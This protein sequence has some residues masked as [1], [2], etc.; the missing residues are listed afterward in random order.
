MPDPAQVV[1]V[2]GARLSVVIP[3]FNEADN[4]TDVLRELRQVLPESEA[5]AVDDGSNDETWERILKCDGA[6]G[7][8]F[9][10]HLGQG[11]A[12]YHGLRMASR[13]L[14]GLMDGDG[15]S[16]PQNFLTLLE[17]YDRGAGDVICGYRVN[18]CD[19]WNRRVGSRIANRLRRIVLDDRVRDTGCAQKLF[20]REHV[21]WLVPFRGLHRYLPALFKQA[22]LRLAEVPLRHRPRRKG[23]SKYRNWNRAWQGL[24]DLV[25]VQWLLRRRLP[26]PTMEMKP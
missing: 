24:Y 8:R 25:G 14:V 26:I 16:D 21:E 18:R 23:Q 6:R 1:D 4:V 19:P 20:R 10:R 11:A 12:I 15:Q 2:R 17:A 3:F 9:H 7:L 5:I 22:G 13:P